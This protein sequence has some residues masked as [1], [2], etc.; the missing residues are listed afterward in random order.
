MEYNMRIDEVNYRA[1]ED[2]EVLGCGK[3]DKFMQDMDAIMEK[4]YGSSEEI[5]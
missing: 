3:E 1:T 2:H 5:T 4:Y